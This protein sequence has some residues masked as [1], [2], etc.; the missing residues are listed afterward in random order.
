MLTHSDFCEDRMPY[1]TPFPTADP[2]RGRVAL[3]VTHHR[4]GSEVDRDLLDS[5]APLTD[6]DRH[7]LANGELVPEEVERHVRA[8]IHAVQQQLWGRSLRWRDD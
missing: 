8:R 2:V 1:Y 6:D 4:I 3:K 7:A 5:Q